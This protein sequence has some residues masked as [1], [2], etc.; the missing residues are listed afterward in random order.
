MI[1]ENTDVTIQPALSDLH[2]QFSVFRYPYVTISEITIWM[3]VFFS[4]Q[5]KGTLTARLA[6]SMELH[7]LAATMVI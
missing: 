3:F 2:I 4:L 5:F 6:Q 7:G 1:Y